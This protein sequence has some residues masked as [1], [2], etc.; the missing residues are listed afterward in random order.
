[1]GDLAL[2]Q[3][4]IGRLSLPSGRLV[5][6]DALA[7]PQA[8]ALGLEIAP[9]EYPVQIA[10]ARTDDGDERI[11]C[12]MLRITD[13]QPTE[14][15]WAVVDAQESEAVSEDELGYGVDSGTACFMSLEAAE[16]LIRR[17]EAEPDYTDRIIAEMEKNYAHTRDWADVVV[18]AQ[19][20]TNLIIFSSGL[21]DG[22]Y[23][24]YWGSNEQ[25]HPVCLL[26][27]FGLLDPEPE[28]A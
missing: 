21:G 11:A 22:I 3:R 26:T 13:E 23:P 10:I 17:V 12:A 25:G 2:E 14:W 24:C 19:G 27:E 16:A 4:A 8:R 20:G 15:Y 6:C 18:D 5:V 7:D 1:M 28:E 9:G